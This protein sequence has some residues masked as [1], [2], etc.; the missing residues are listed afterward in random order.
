M[1]PTSQP[2]GQPARQRPSGNNARHGVSR[3]AMPIVA[4]CWVSG[5]QAQAPTQFRIHDWQPAATPVTLQ[6]AAGSPSQALKPSQTAPASAQLCL[7]SAAAGQTLVQIQPAEGGEARFI[8]LGGQVP[9]CQTIGTAWAKAP[10]GEAPWYKTLFAQLGTQPGGARISA[11]TS[12]ATRGGPANAPQSQDTPTDP[13]SLYPSAKGIVYVASG[14]SALALGTSL[15]Q[16]T[17]AHLQRQPASEPTL[18]AEV[19]Q[20]RLQWP[21][22][23]WVAGDR[24]RIAVQTQT[25]GA[26]IVVQPNSA[27][28]LQAARAHAP[29]F[30][31]DPA[32]AQ[33]ALVAAQLDD[34]NL[35]AWNAWLLATIAPAPRSAA[36]DMGTALWH[37]WWSQHSQRSQQHGNNRP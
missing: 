24:W 23:D 26:T 15:P 5:A 30:A 28:P 13:C 32:T 35:T 19:A 3:W 2:A 31:A 21:V 29:R 18:T 7:P 12:G 8:A 36:E 17:Q 22:I 14:S 10:T 27:N 4:V 1:T 33:A 34:P 11:S 37:A 20:G 16:G 9:Q 6:T 25:C